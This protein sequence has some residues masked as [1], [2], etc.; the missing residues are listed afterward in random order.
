VLRLTF[1]DMTAERP[2]ELRATK[3]VHAKCGGT[4]LQRVRIERNSVL[5]P[6]HKIC[7]PQRIRRPVA[8]GLVHGSNLTGATGGHT[9]A[10]E[11][12]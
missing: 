9:G 4:R 3:T 10:G 12:R 11:P 2:P 8:E 7:T 1:E 5:S 6:F